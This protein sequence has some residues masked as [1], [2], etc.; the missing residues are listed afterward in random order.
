MFD[1]RISFGI[2]DESY[3]KD[4]NSYG[5]SKENIFAYQANGQ[6][7]FIGFIKFDGSGF[8]EGDTIDFVL[9]QDE[10]IIEWRVNGVV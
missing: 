10:G 1:G 3:L 9:F 6:I 7:Q 8:A 2:I 4:R 5:N